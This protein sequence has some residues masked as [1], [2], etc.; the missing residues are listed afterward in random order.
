MSAPRLTAI[1]FAATLMLTLTVVA[2]APPRHVNPSGLPSDMPSPFALLKLYKAVGEALIAEDYDEAFGILR[3]GFEVDAPDDVKYILGRFNEVMADTI[4][5][6][7]LTRAIVNEIRA[8][9]QLGLLLKARNLLS[10]GFITLARANIT[11]ESLSAIASELGK[12]VRANMTPV[13]DDVRTAIE[14]LYEE[15]LDVNLMIE[16][17]A[18]KTPLRTYV[19]VN[20]DPPEAWVGS[21]V[22]VYGELRTA[23]GNA[24]PG[25]VIKVHL[26][27]LSTDAMTDTMGR[28]EVHLTAP[29][30]YVPF[31]EVYSEYV[32]HGQDVGMY[33]AS[34]SRV[35][36]LKLLYVKPNLT[37]SLNCT[38]A[39][40]L[41]AITVSG[42][43][44]PPGTTVVLVSAF[45]PSLNVST[46]QK[47]FFRTLMIVPG[48]VA[49]GVYEITVRSYPNGTL[50]P[51]EASAAVRVYRVP[52]EVR[53]ERP[54]IVWSGS[55]FVLRG[56]VVEA[57][58]GEPVEGV[59]RI[60]CYGGVVIAGTREG[61]FEVTLKAPLT[62]LSGWEPVNVTFV[63]S[64]PWLSE[65]YAE[66]RILTVNP[67]AIAASAALVSAAVK[68]VRPRLLS[69]TRRR[70]ASAEAKA[71]QVRPEEA[72]GTTTATESP[73][74]PLDVPSVY[75]AA[76]KM[77][78]AVTRTMMRHYHTPREFL[79]L[80][81]PRMS[82]EASRAFSALTE[83]LERYL[84]GSEPVKI[85]EARSMLKRL[86]GALR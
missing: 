15:L 60:A 42:R 50:A 28:Y 76:V 59:V 40:P 82:E 22:R 34:T 27:S 5:R 43:I 41:D 67:Y 12:R 74:E 26:G 31:I 45:G 58:T 30:T 8:L 68:A 81:L 13:V 56:R 61:S 33:M 72:H 73:E 14:N 11:L 51:A 52:V 62:R 17:L 23:D 65:G 37:I 69:V 19:T 36:H 46:D 7:N 3:K 35:I 20:V 70:E 78:E 21:P 18:A 38:E 54:R 10:E 71:Y 79:R 66:A 39:K 85:G 64:D 29:Y 84:Y 6:L 48:D 32:P 4:D 77:V 24:L 75:M 63:P 80:V 55:D 1:A 49:E 25:R 16:E 53:L 47:G 57:D 83:M 44:W 9:A 86:E 2:S